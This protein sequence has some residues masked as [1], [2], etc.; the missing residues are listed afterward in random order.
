MAATLH[1]QEIITN[2]HRQPRLLR[3][4]DEILPDRYDRSCI[5]SRYIWLFRTGIHVLRSREDTVRIIVNNKTY[6]SHE[7]NGLPVGCNVIYRLHIGDRYVEREGLGA[8]HLARGDVLRTMVYS[9]TE[10]S[11]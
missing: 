4:Y 3:E 6:H 5:Y 1:I 7:Y 11:K 9:V 10:V 2:K 8:I